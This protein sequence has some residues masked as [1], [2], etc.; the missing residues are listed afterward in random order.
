MITRT[1]TKISGVSPTRK[2][3]QN[4]AKPL[5]ERVTMSP[6]CRHLDAPRAFD[7]RSHATYAHVTTR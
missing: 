6:S 1:A 7:E 5:S 3:H 4:I 2:S